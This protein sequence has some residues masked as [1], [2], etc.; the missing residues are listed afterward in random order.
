[1]PFKLIITLILAL[2]S[3]NLAAQRDTVVVAGN[4]TIFVKD[5]TGQKDTIN[6]NT[7]SNPKRAVLYSAILPGLGQAY[8]RKYWKIPIVYGTIGTTLFLA[9]Y[10]NKNYNRFLNA[11][12]A[13]T[14]NDTTTINQ[15]SAI[16][17]EQIK[18]YK[19]KYKRDRDLF[20]IV[21]GVL[22]IFNLVDASVDAHFADYDVGDDLSLHIEPSIMPLWGK[23]ENAYGLSLA[24]R[25]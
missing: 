5:I 23:Q 24:F 2:I 18:F 15:L 22:Y 19:K 20:L 12:I 10:N 7:D 8:N 21:T 13:E 9:D 11:Y 16:G 25:F 17:L 6:I 4:D 1:M 14:D 3:L